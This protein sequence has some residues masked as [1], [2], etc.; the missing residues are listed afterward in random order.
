MF[1]LALKIS[2]MSVKPAILSGLIFFFAHSSPAA[3][4]L[5]TF[6]INYFVNPFNLIVGKELV[7]KE[8][9]TEP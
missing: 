7:L 8:A 3:G 1:V 5:N 9:L 2:M 4:V 6:R